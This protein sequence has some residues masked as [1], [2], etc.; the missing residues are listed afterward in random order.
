MQFVPVIGEEAAAA[1][2]L[3]SLARAIAL[4]GEIANGALSIYDTVQDP[5]SAVVNILGMLFGL[6]SFAKVERDGEGIA[7]LAKIRNAMKSSE[8]SS[9]GSIFKSNDD[10]LQS[11][12]KVCN[13]K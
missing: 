13:V 11:I 5:S 9:L 10:T 12:M 1:A 6:G 7:S 2:G 8:I 4:A 3:A